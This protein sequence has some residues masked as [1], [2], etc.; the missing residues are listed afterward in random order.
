MTALEFNPGFRLSL[1]DI[2]VLF[3]LGHFFYFCNITRMSRIPKLI[4]TVC[5]C[6][7]SK[8]DPNL[9]AWFERDRG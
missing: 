5:Y 4:W 8:L 1:F 9:K 2:V 3:V 6:F 7:L